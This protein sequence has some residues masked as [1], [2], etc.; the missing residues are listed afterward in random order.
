[1]RMHLPPTRPPVPRWQQPLRDSPGSADALDP[2]IADATDNSTNTSFDIDAFA[3]ISTAA[4]SVP[5][6]RS[7]L[8]RH[9]QARGPCLA[10]AGGSAAAQRGCGCNAVRQRVDTG[11]EARQ[12]L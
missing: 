6:I 7:C 8:L 1:M 5:Q 9:G 4:A 3:T 11:D 10:C 2:P 12:Q